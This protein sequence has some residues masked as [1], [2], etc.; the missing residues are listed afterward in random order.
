MVEAEGDI[1]APCAQGYHHVVHQVVLRLLPHGFLRV[2]RLVEGHGVD[3]LSRSRTVLIHPGGI[4]RVFRLLV[5]HHDGEG[6]LVAPHA[7]VE[8]EGD[9][10]RAFLLGQKDVGALGRQ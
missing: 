6:V 3:K 10:V 7:V 5:Q 8:G 9:A 1:A 4:G 2:A